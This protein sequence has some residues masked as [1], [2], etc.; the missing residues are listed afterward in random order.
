M[1]LCWRD[2]LRAFFEIFESFPWNPVA[3]CDDF[4]LHDFNVFCAVIFPGPSIW[5]QERTKYGDELLP[6]APHFLLFDRL[7]VAVGQ[8]QMN[9]VFPHKTSASN[10]RCV[11]LTRQGSWPVWFIFS[12]P[13]SD[14][15]KVCDCL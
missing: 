4:N 9:L 8:W 14:V 3:G 1:S 7:A 12:A 5:H 13:L 2:S 6:H 10:L 15:R 11:M